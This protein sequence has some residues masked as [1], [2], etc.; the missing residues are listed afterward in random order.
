MVS[1]VLTP[2]P[3][4]TTMR[5]VVSIAVAA[6]AVQKSLLSS[7]TVQMCQKDWAT[8]SNKCATAD[9]GICNWMGINIGYF[10]SLMFVVIASD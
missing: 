3:Y 2:H 8:S 6:A 1:S 4:I 5:I 7:K 10:Y 9:V